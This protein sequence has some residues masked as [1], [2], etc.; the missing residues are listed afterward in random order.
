MAKK[1]NHSREKKELTSEQIKIDK[2]TLITSLFEIA[3]LIRKGWLI[4][5]DVPITH[6]LAR[7]E[8]LERV[9]SPDRKLSFKQSFF[10]L[11]G[12]VRELQLIGYWAHMA[13]VTEVT[14][15]LYESISFALIFNT[16]P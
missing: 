12:D 10:Y 11:L 16:E 9:G 7:R 1:L 14:I 15:V 4:K 13:S 8:S 5:F 6:T 2:I 3:H